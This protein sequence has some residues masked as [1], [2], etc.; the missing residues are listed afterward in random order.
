MDEKP[1]TIKQA[2]SLFPS[3]CS[4]KRK[5]FFFFFCLCPPLLRRFF[6]ILLLLCVRQQQS[7]R[8]GS[9][10]LSGQDACP[11]RRSNKT[12]KQS[13]EDKGSF[14]FLDEQCLLLLLNYH[15]APAVVT[16]LVSQRRR[17]R[18]KWVLFW[19][20]W[21]SIFDFTCSIT[22]KNI[23]SL[24]NQHGLCLFDL[25]HRRQEECIYQDFYPTFL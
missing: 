16:R 22:F 18:Q 25:L 8:R 6:C 21:Q 23:L 1:T 10:T 7:Y 5:D 4:C 12:A 2:I 20:L 14:A 11:Q 9:L 13:M 24:K 17:R 15:S 19:N 3:F